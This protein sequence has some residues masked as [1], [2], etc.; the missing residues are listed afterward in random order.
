VSVT[1]AVGGQYPVLNG[2]A[3]TPATTRWRSFAQVLHHEPHLVAGPQP[4]SE[5]LGV[6]RVVLEQA[7]GVHRAR[8]DHVADPA[9]VVPREV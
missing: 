7:A 1:V 6:D 3:L 9:S 5:V 8:A 4:A 2:S